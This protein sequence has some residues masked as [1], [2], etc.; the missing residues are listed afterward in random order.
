M[1]EIL[2]PLSPKRDKGNFRGAV[3]NTGAFFFFFPDGSA[4]SDVWIVF[5]SQDFFQ[6]SS[7][8]SFQERATLP[9][10]QPPPSRSQLF[11]RMLWCEC[12]VE[13]QRWRGEVQTESPHG[14]NQGFCSRCFLIYFTLLAAEHGDFIFFETNC[15]LHVMFVY[16][17][18]SQ[19]ASTFTHGVFVARHVYGKEYICNKWSSC[20]MLLGNWLEESTCIFRG[21]LLNF[22][23]YVELLTIYNHCNPYNLV[24]KFV[25]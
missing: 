12:Q 25:P 9:T 21:E 1:Y 18:V 24:D 11:L 8:C 10:P 3:V 22:G 7:C 13:G 17:R 2:D 14:K 23:V 16:L 20:L 19:N 15:L 6:G 5:Q 4:K